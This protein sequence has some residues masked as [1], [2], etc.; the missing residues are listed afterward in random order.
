MAMHPS[1]TT[2]DDVS[3]E[4]T[5]LLTRQFTHT[6]PSLQPVLRQLCILPGEACW[7][8][9]IDV[10]VLAMAGNLVDALFLATKAAL[11]TTSLPQTT[12]HDLGDERQ[13]FEIEDASLVPLV[14]IHQLPLCVTV[15][16]IGPHPLL[17]ASVM[18]EQVATAKLYVFVSPEQKITHVEKAGEGSIEASLLSDMVQQGRTMAMQ[19][20]DQLHQVLTLEHTQAQV[21][22]EAGIQY[23]KG[24]FFS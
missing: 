12:L 2:D 10:L 6:S 9:Y 24:L 13:G 23:K 7:V 20:H 17:D 18:E 19:L 11:L 5:Q 21:A 8:V 3:N 14:D 4:L 16:K 22:K 1:S 15:Y